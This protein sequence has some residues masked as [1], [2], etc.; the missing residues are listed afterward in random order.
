ME[1]R[2]KEISVLS[3]VAAA[4]VAM[5]LFFFDPSRTPIYPVC[6]FHKWTGLNCPGCGSLRALHQMLHGNIVEALRLNALLVLSIP[7]F[8]WLGVRL[9]RQRIHG[10]PGL[11]VRPLWIWIYGATWI[12]FGVVRE[13]PVP[14]FAAWSP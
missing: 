9:V 13:L 10:A 11:A 1:S 4:G 3:V 12:V 8:V 5:L 2:I 7:V 6:L 14:L